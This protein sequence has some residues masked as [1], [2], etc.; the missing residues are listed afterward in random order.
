MFPLKSESSTGLHVQAR[1]AAVQNASSLIGS[2]VGVLSQRGERDSPS[3]ELIVTQHNNNP[4]ALRQALGG[5]GVGTKLNGQW[6]KD[7]ALVP[8]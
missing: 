2:E 4:N 6:G 3:A 1:L 8:G 5:G 7:K